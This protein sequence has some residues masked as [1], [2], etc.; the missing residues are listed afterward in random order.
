MKADSMAVLDDVIGGP[1]LGF[2]SSI[3]Q[4]STKLK[5]TKLWEKEHA[6]VAGKKQVRRTLINH[7]YRRRTKVSVRTRNNS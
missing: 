5:G 1:S 6:V 4:N 3:G 7:E 2:R